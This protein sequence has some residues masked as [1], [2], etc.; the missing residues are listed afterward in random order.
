MAKIYLLACRSLIVTYLSITVLIVVGVSRQ[1]IYD[2]I[3][4]EIF[5]MFRV[6]P[7]KSVL[8]M[9]RWH[10]GNPKAHSVTV[11]CFLSLAHTSI[12]WPDFLA[13]ASPFHYHHP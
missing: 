4:R 10:V 12:P 7:I 3:Q 13:V 5:L 11:L 9:E 8:P 2:N 6:L 1:N